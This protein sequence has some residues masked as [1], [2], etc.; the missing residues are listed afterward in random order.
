MDVECQRNTELSVIKGILR[1]KVPRMPL[2]RSETTAMGTSC[3]F[4]P[5]KPFFLLLLKKQ[6]QQKETRH[7]LIKR[8]TDLI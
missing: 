3:F 5:P 6:V 1:A 4:S 7:S 2:E 8:A